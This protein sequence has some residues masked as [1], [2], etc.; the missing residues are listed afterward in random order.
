[1]LEHTRHC[2]V[3]RKNLNEL[4]TVPDFPLCTLNLQIG[5]AKDYGQE[6]DARRDERVSGRQGARQSAAEEGTSTLE[7]MSPSLS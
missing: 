6:D 4:E 3:A 1:M 7:G 5:G 2:F